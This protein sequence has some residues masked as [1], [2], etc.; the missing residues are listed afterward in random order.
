MRNQPS[1]SEP[2]RGIRVEIRPYKF[3]EL[4]ALYKTSPNTFRRWL[5]R[6][7]D[8]LGELDGHYYSIKQVKIIFNELN[9]PSY[10]I[11]DE[12]IE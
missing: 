2:S 9:H 7:K 6:F 3:K 4:A 11:I 5:N 1:N 10:A 8:K 12:I